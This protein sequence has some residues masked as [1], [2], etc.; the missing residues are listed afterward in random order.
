MLEEVLMPTLVSSRLCS[1]WLP[2]LDFLVLVFHVGM[3]LILKSSN[4]QGPLLPRAHC[5]LTW[6]LFIIFLSLEFLLF[7]TLGG[8][9][10]MMSGK[11]CGLGILVDMELIF[12]VDSSFSK[13]VTWLLLSDFDSSTCNTHLFVNFQL[14]NITQAYQINEIQIHIF[15]ITNVKVN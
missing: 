6:I 13:D 7:L 2:L 15:I 8:W 4:T 14:V 1:F 5:L 9:L 3:E 10:V 11:G 12:N